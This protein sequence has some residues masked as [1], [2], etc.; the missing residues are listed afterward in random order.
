MCFWCFILNKYPKSFGGVKWDFNNLSMVVCFDCIKEHFDDDWNPLFISQYIELPWEDITLDK[1]GNFGVFLKDFRLIFNSEALA[2]NES[3]P[4]EFIKIYPNSHWNS[5]T[6][7]SSNKLTWE[8]VQNNPTGFENIPW[9]IEILSEKLPLHFIRRYPNGLSGIPWNTNALSRNPTLTNDF[10]ELHPKGFGDGIWDVDSLSLNENI[11]W[12]FFVKYYLGMYGKKWPM[13]YL[14]SRVIPDFL[15]RN[16]RFFYGQEWDSH[17]LSRNK[18]ITW[19]LIENNM[20][21]S[22]QSLKINFNHE[23]ILER[24]DLPMSLIKNLPSSKVSQFSRSPSLSVDFLEKN[25]TGI[26]GTPWCVYSLC[27][28]DSITWDFF[29]KYQYGFCGQTWPIKILSLREWKKDLNENRFK[30]VKPAL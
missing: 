20:Q 2:L 11:T 21:L 26:N 17:S 18:N 16:P 5:L 28:N 14:S 10:V 29:E 19:E 9:D 12:D 7:S 24:A 1:S 8:I 22:D 23:I 25:L 3:I 6:I 15:I 4:L 13:K 27:W 30:K